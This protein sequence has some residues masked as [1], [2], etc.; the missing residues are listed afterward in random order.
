MSAMAAARE[1][2]SA[3]TPRKYSS[4]YTKVAPARASRSH[5]GRSTA[6]ATRAA[7]RASG[8]VTNGASTLASSSGRE[9]GLTSKRKRH[10]LAAATSGCFREIRRSQRPYSKARR[11]QP[12]T[13]AWSE[14]WRTRAAR[15]K[16]NAT[17]ALRPDA[18]RRVLGRE[19]RDQAHPRHVVSRRNDTFPV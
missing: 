6:S 18:A 14:L 13:L 12:S 4:P 3:R 10:G 5:P 9:I 11:I 1:P 17:P 8:R 7:R 15:E 2:A 16:D 19:A